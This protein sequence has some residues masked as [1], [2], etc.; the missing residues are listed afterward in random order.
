MQ[1][2]HWSTVASNWQSRSLKNDRCRWALL[3]TPLLLGA[4]V[5]Q[6]TSSVCELSRTE[7]AVCHRTY[8]SVWWMW[9]SE[10]GGHCPWQTTVYLGSFSLPLSK[11]NPA[12]SWT[13]RRLSSLAC[14]VQPHG[15]PLLNP[16]SSAG[17]AC[18]A[19]ERQL[20][21]KNISSSF[22][23]MFKHLSLV[24]KQSRLCP[25][26]RRVSMFADPKCEAWTRQGRAQSPVVLRCYWP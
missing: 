4:V 14:P 16:T 19:R 25:L 15:V 18:T 10:G 13:H 21:G 5:G 3:F 8:S 7:T 6:K 12:L 26:L 9:C 2:V 11:K 23:Q 17:T 1:I 24:R 22:L 20:T